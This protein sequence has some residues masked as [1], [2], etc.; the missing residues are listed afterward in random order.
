MT[1][2]QEESGKKLEA[3]F[4]LAKLE[5]PVV[6]AEEVSKILKGAGTT[7]VAALLFQQYKYWLL[8]GLSIV[9]GVAF[10]FMSSNADQNTVKVNRLPAIENIDEASAKTENISSS[11][12]EN[13]KQKTEGK[14][15]AINTSI[16][17]LKERV[18]VKKEVFYFPGKAK[19]HFEENGRNVEMLIGEKVSELKIDG[20]LIDP[21]EYDQHQELLN[22]GIQMKADSDKEATSESNKMPEKERNKNTMNEII[23]QLSDDNLVDPNGKF[24]FRLTGTGL[25]INEILQSE[26]LYIKY[27]ELYQN[28]SGKII[29]EKSNIKIRH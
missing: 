26:S 18:S 13:L 11:N 16:S 28:K 29:T 12:I 8:G 27:K 20:E 7:A 1:E 6:S 14:K 19:V 10:Y 17:E 23:K 21:S 25:Y 5:A 9:S 24:E 4:E 3:Y 22:K 15:L 2:E